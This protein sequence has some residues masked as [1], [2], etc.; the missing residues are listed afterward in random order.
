MFISYPT[1]SE[2]TDICNIR[3]EHEVEIFTLNSNEITKVDLLS[4]SSSYEKIEIDEEVF[5]KDEQLYTTKKGLEQAFH[6]T[7]EYDSKNNV[8]SMYSL[9]TYITSLI[10]PDAQGQTII[11]KYG[12]EKIDEDYVNQ[13]AIIDDMIVV[14]TEQ[15]KYGVINYSTGEPILGVQYDSIKYLPQNSAFLVKTNNKY[16]IIDKEG[17]TK[18]QPIYDTLEQIDSKKQLYL[19]SNNKLYG[20]V[21]LNG[22]EIIHLEYD[23]IGI[24]IS[25]FTENDITNGYIIADTLIPVCQEDVWGFFDVNGKQVTDLIYENVGC[26]TQNSQGTSHN[27]LLIPNYNIIIVEKVG[28]Y[29]GI[30][31]EGKEE[32]ST[33]YNEIYMQTVSGQNYYAG[34]RTL[35]GE[36]RTRDLLK[37]LEEL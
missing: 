19:V 35:N 20:I 5:K 21:N 4:K 1:A 11:Q 2:S 23:K 37:Y 26:V 32:L 33:I 14:V 18:I 9:D 28:L 31:L 6:I 24:D 17:K 8:I 10:T 34:K 22:Q 36:T 27:V 3:N 13:Q 29:G 7:I 30:N 15:N 12:Y 16:G 25:K